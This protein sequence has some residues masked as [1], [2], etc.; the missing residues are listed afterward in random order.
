VRRTSLQPLE[1]RAVNA[2]V[3]GWLGTAVLVIVVLAILKA[4]PMLD[5]TKYVPVIGGPR[6]AA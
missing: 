2:K 5:V 6:P 1:V 4:V 3:K